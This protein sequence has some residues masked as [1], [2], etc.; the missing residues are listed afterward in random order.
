MRLYADLRIK[1]LVSSYADIGSWTGSLSKTLLWAKVWCRWVRCLHCLQKRGGE[2]ETRPCQETS[3][4]LLSQ[5]ANS[6][7]LALNTSHRTLLH[8]IDVGRVTFTCHTY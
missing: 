5:T 1:N 7:A 2:L 6:G 8:D 4:T 3:S